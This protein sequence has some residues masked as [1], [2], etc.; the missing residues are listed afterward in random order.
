[1]TRG[2]E[3]GGYETKQSSD[4]DSEKKKTSAYKRPKQNKDTNSKTFEYNSCFAAKSCMMMSMQPSGNAMRQSMNDP[5][6]LTLQIDAEHIPPK[7]MSCHV[8]YSGGL[9]MRS[10]SCTEASLTEMSS[11]MTCNRTQYL[12]CSCSRKVPCVNLEPPRER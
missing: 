3:R 12:T 8:L 1:M 7:K 6:K 4:R 2:R 11:W 5:L 9:R 10:S